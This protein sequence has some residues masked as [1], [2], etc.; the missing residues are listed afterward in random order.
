MSIAN[1]KI[2]INDIVR[3]RWPDGMKKTQ[4]NITFTVLGIPGNQVMSDTWWTLSGNQKTEL[5][6]VT[7]L[8]M[9][10]VLTP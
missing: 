4:D 10:E 9:L 7:E 2:E 3:I 5:V 6:V 8:I 1:G